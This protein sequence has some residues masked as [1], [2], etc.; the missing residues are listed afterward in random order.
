MLLAQEIFDIVSRHLLT[1]NCRSENDNEWPCYRGPW[2]R[3]C[4]IGCLLMPEHYDPKFEHLGVCLLRCRQ[5]GTLEDALA[6]ALIQ[7]GIDIDN[8]YIFEVCV[9]LQDCHDVV[10]VDR[11][12]HE[13]DAIARKH[14][15]A[16]QL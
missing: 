8:P 1:Q 10:P 3:S 14:G 6:N 5:S 11:W 12:Y 9:D 15:L 4:A 2:G 16:F 13:L 7:S